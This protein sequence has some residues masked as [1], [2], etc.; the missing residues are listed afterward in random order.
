MGIYESENDGESWTKSSNGLPLDAPMRE[1]IVTDFGIIVGA[2]L[3][4]R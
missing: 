4:K 1:L 3:N 2:G